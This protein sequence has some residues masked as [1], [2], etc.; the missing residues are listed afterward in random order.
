[1]CES[2]AFT[3]RALAREVFARTIDGRWPVA[4]RP[5]C[6]VPARTIY[7]AIIRV[8]RGH[9][10]GAERGVRMPVFPE[11][12]SCNHN[13][14]RFLNQ[15]PR[16]DPCLKPKLEVHLR[17]RWQCH[18]VYGSPGAALACRGDQ[19]CFSYSV[20]EETYSYNT[21]TRQEIGRTEQVE[22]TKVPTSATTSN[23]ACSG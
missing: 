7:V 1:M 15:K 14:C 18:S 23:R 12:Q 2:R 10:Y 3:M 11:I 21:R 13:G 17:R 4:S 8:T 22:A 5:Q 6:R 16:S 19:I 20:V 9:V